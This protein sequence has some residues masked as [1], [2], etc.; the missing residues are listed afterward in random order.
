MVFVKYAL[1]KNINQN[2]KY[3]LK[4]L[5][6]VSRFQMSKRNSPIHK[7][8]ENHSELERNTHNRYFKPYSKDLK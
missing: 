8:G 3:K 7:S 2:D 1:F 5:P 4:V 6:A